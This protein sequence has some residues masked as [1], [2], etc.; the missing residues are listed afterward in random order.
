MHELLLVRVKA[1]EYGLFNASH[2]WLVLLEP[3]TVAETSSPMALPTSL[4]EVE[5]FKRLNINMNSEIT[6]A[7]PHQAAA[8]AASTIEK[9][10]WD[11]YDLYDMW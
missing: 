10:E 8:V 6:L 4:V 11:R 1:S 5:F 9:P 2:H 7:K 3:S